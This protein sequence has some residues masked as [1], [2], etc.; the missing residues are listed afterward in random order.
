MYEYHVVFT[1]YELIATV[2]I[3]II[4]VFVAFAVYKS[5]K[6]K[7]DGNFIIAL[8]I[9]A[10]IFLTLSPLRSKMDR[11]LEDDVINYFIEHNMQPY[12]D[13]AY[14]EGY[15]TGYEDGFND[16]SP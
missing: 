8:I 5:A 14:N 16:A 6:N 11:N 15:K 1:Q 12:L 13:D 9:A 4:T 2:I 10:A 3:V 7:E